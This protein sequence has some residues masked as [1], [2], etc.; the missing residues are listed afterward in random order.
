[1]SIWQQ[2]GFAIALG[3]VTHALFAV[4]V[5]VMFVGI[6]SGLRSGLGH[7]HGW[8]GLAVDALLILQFPVLHSFFLSRPGRAMLA[9]VAPGELGANLTTTTYALVA[10]LQLLAAFGLWS[11][12][13]LV[14]Y[15]ATGGFYWISLA[16]YIASWA[17]LIKALTDA[18]LGL[19]TG[20]MGWSAVARGKNPAYRDFPTHG[21]FRVCRHP[22]YLGFSLIL[23]TAPVMTP[24]GLLLAALW[25]IYCATGPR[26]KEARYRRLYGDRY[27]Q[28]CAAVPYILPTSR[29][30]PHDWAEQN[31]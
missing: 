20:F 31:A 12:S 5:T 7:L 16:L 13:G 25:T 11:P 15:E 6:Y 14:V 17:F 21:L 28:Y 26:L 10:S 29:R 3:V 30:L 18:G 23:W 2:R 1:M 9:K 4:S 27:D 19:Q 8:Q 22:V 24:D